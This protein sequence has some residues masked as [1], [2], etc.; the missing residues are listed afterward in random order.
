MPGANIL[1]LFIPLHRIATDLKIS[2]NVS[3]YI[4]VY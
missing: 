3:E 1:L 2:K 4:T